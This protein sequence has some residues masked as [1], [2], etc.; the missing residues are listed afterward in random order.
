MLVSHGYGNGYIAVYGYGTIGD[1]VVQF[2]STIRRFFCRE[3]VRF[4]A[5]DV[6]RGGPLEI[7][8]GLTHESAGRDRLATGSRKRGSDV[9]R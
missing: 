8:R 7:S 6:N 9:I 3:V 4:R 5:H 1:A 2:F